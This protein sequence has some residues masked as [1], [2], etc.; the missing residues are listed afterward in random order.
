MQ[1]FELQFIR[2]MKVIGANPLDAASTGE[3]RVLSEL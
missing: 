3:A 1:V 2:G